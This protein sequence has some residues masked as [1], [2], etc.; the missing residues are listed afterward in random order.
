MMSY[1]RRRKCDSFH[2]WPDRLR[3]TWWLCSVILRKA[4]QVPTLDV[5]SFRDGLTVEGIQIFPF[6]C[7]LLVDS[8]EPAGM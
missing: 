5:R 6:Q 2:S 7:M 3:H 8:F 1:H 4:S